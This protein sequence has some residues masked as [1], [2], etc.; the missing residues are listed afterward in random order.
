M[1]AKP[2]ASLS[3]ADLQQYP[4]WE[5]VLDEDSAAGAEPVD[6]SFVR[7]TEH[8]QIPKA[9]F[10][11][12]AQFAQFAVA[13]SVKLK[14]GTAFP[15]IAE[16]TVANG[17]I[18]IQPNVVFLLDRQLTIPG[19]ETNR[20]LTRYTKTVENYPVGWT[21]NVLIDGETKPRSGKIRGGDM[22]HVV[23]AGIQILMSLKALRSKSND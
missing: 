20:L 3:R 22:K 19:V 5:W 2:Y 18:A 16:L 11:Q 13:S 9:E 6:E 12:F 14:D 15:G 1:Q 10:A 17:K 7:P 4:I 21:L 23:A 8:A